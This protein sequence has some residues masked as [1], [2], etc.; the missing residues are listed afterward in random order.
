M[1][2]PAR[3]FVSASPRITAL[4]LGLVV[5]ANAGAQNRRSVT[6]GST[7]DAA[8]LTAAMDDYLAK[9]IGHRT[10]EI[11]IAPRAL[12]FFNTHAGALDR[13]PLARAK[14]VKSR[15]VFTDPESG[16]VVARTG[17]ELED[18]RIAYASTRLQIAGGS[19]TQVETSFD[20][21]PRVVPSYVTDLDPLMTT[22][23]P[24]GRRMSRAEL[25]A[26]IGRYFQG[27]TDHKA[28]ASD[29]DDR[30]DR[31]HSGQRITNNPRITVEGGKTVTC[32]TAILGNPPWGP[33]TDLHIPLVDPEHG[34][35][36]GYT[37]LL[38][39]DGTAPMYVSEVFKILHGKI[40]M[41]DN[42][43]LKA[44]DMKATG[45]PE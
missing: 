22:V 24:A 43:G 32:Y 16:N 18:G 29:F 25:K 6:A 14:S 1:N 10:S 9:V 41:I 12:V 30:C 27:L 36:V 13:N 37:L 15:Q 39:H 20:D 26:T 17:V 11:R 45:F 38:Y 8:C 4:A 31:Y 3:V 2:H 40:R 23:V 21:S 19:I 33:A 7:C 34:I 28:M 5:I 35:V 42:I 44:E